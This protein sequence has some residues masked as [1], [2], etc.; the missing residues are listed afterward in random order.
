MKESWV[1]DSLVASVNYKRND[2]KLDFSDLYNLLK[3]SSFEKLKRRLMLLPKKKK[4]RRRL[5]YINYIL[6]IVVM[7]KVNYETLIYY[8]HT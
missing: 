3:T 5:M 4:K 7:Y 1:Q 6:I 2:L 8:Y